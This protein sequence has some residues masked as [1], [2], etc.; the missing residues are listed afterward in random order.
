MKRIAILAAALLLLVYAALLVPLLHHAGASGLAAAFTDPRIL[1]AMRLTVT[2]ALLA[3]CLSL[4]LAIPAAYA[5]SRHDFPG[6][7]A[8]E[9]VLELPLVISPVALGAALLLFFNTGA[10]RA[11]ESFAGGFV[12]AF[13][14]IV[15]AQ[16]VS[17]AGFAAR[18]AKAAF[19]EVPRR[20][21]AVAATL[22]APPATVFLRVVLPQARRGLLAAFILTFAKCTG[23]FGATVT[24]A[25]AMPGRTETLPVSIFLRIS[26]FDLPGVAATILV[27]VALGLTLTVAARLLLRRGA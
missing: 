14:G 4:A 11:I 19:D 1:A 9:A 17:T 18:V 12:Y 2:A 20:T 26:S 22:G 25:G 13:A 21:E 8:V 23:E 5:L 24:L 6:R 27:L 7:G 3:T 10:G 16:F 15:L